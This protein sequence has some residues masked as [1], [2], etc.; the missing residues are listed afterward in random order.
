MKT[1][2]N[3]FVIILVLSILSPLAI[4]SKL[5]SGLELKMRNMVDNEKTRVL[6][7]MKEKAELDDVRGNPQLV[8]QKL[9]TVA[10]KSQRQSLLTISSLQN[11]SKVPQYRSFWIVNCISVTG[12]KGAIKQLVK[13]RNVDKIIE[14]PVIPLPSPA[15]SLET[16]TTPSNVQW[17]I[18]QIGIDRVW[19]DFGYRGEGIVIGCIDTGVD[20]SHPELVNKMAYIGNGEV[21]WF[22]AVR[23]TT[24]P[25]DISDIPHGTHVMGTMVGGNLSGSY[26][27]VAPNAKYYMAK[28]F[29]STGA[30]GTDILEAAQWMMDPDDNPETDDFPDVI[31]NSWGGT[32][33][34]NTWFE[35]MYKSWEA[36]GIFSAFAGGNAGPD[37]NTISDPAG[38]PEVFAVG[39]TTSTDD[40]ASFSS[41]G[42]VYWQ[43]RDGLNPPARTVIKPDI[44]APGQGIKSSVPG[45]YSSWNGTSMAT[46][47]IT[48]IA[49]LIR[50]ANPQISLQQ[51][52]K[53]LIDNSIDLG[54]SGKDNNFGYGRVDAY[55]A[56]S[57][58]V[59]GGTLNG[60]VS[61]DSQRISNAVVEVG[62]ITTKTDANGEF[63]LILQAG[64]Y[65]VKVSKV[66]YVTKE[67]SGIV[68]E[69]G[70]TKSLNITILPA[71]S[72]IIDGTVTD[73]NNSQPVSATVNVISTDISDNTDASTGQ[74]SF[75]LPEGQY[76]IEVK[77]K[78]YR[79]QTVSVDVIADDTVTQDFLL[80]PYDLAEPNDNFDSAFGINIG[81]LFEADINPA[82]DQDFYS[83]QGSSG[84]RVSIDVDAGSLSPTSELDSILTLYDKNQTLI[85]END[86]YNDFDPRINGFSLPS[87]GIYYVRVKSFWDDVGGENYFYVLKIEPSAPNNLIATS[88][89]DSK[90]VLEWDTVI[91]D[92]LS[93]MNSNQ[94]TFTVYNIYKSETPNVEVIES[95]K[96]NLEPI[97]VT[98]YVDEN[99]INGTTYYYVVTAIFD[100]GET[101]PSNEV[102]ARPGLTDNYE[103]N[104]DFA[105]A[106]EINYFDVVSN[107]TINP[108]DDHD[109]F[110]FSGI[111]GQRIR[112]YIE[113]RSLEPPSQ[114]DSILYLY[115]ANQQILTQNN[116]YNEQ[117]SLIEFK[118][119]EDG[120]YFLKVKS[121]QAVGGEEYFY[122]LNIV[123]VGPAELQAQSG[124]ER[125]VILTWENNFETNVSIAQDTF[126]GY[127][128]YRNTMPNVP[129]DSAYLINSNPI[130]DSNYEDTDVL[131]GTAYYYVITTVYESGES[132]P[133]NE[134]NAMPGPADEY[135]PNN[136]FEHATTIDYNQSITDVTIDPA[137]DIDFFKFSG[138]SEILVTIDV[139]AESLDPSSQLDSVLT[140]YDAN[141][142]EISNNDDFDGRDS[143]IEFFKLTQNDIYYIKV[144]DYYSSNG[145]QD[146]N[147]VLTVKK[148]GPSNLEAQSKE[149][150]IELS[151]SSIPM[152]NY[153]PT[154]YSNDIS[155]SS[156]TYNIYRTE[157]PGV[158]A[159]EENRINELPVDNTSYEDTDVTSGIKYYYVVTAIING[160]ETAPS[161][162]VN[163]KAGLADAYEPNDEFETAYQISFGQPIENATI[164][165]SGDLDY[166][167][168]TGISGQLVT[169]DVN[170]E[171][172]ESP[173]ELDSVLTLFDSNHNE[174]VN[175]DD[176]DG[177]DPRIE[178]F[179]LPRDG[180][181]YIRI[182]PFFLSDG[183]EEFFYNLII[184][185][186]ISFNLRAQS[187]DSHVLL[188][189]D[190]VTQVNYNPTKTQS[191]EQIGPQTL[192]GYNV[193]RSESSG[194]EISEENRLN[195]IPIKE[196]SYDD[197]SVENGNSYFY[198]VTAVF[199]T[200]ESAPSKEVNATP[201]IPD[202]YEPNDDM[203]TATGIS[204]SASLENAIIN[205]PEV[206][207]DWY[208]F[209]G[210]AGQ[211]VIIETLVDLSLNV[212]I[213]LV[214]IDS[215]GN[216]LAHPEPDSI[217][218]VIEDFQLSESGIYYIQVSGEFVDGTTM[219]ENKI[220]Y[221]I[222]IDL[223]PP[224]NLTAENGLENRIPLSWDAPCNSQNSLTYNVYRRES[225][226]LPYSKIN[227]E[228]PI[229]DT[230]FDDSRVEEGQTYYY[231]VTTIYDNIE[232]CFSNEALGRSG[233]IDPNEP[234]DEMNIATSIEVGER[235]SSSAI[236]SINDKDYYVF[237]ASKEQGIVIDI[238]SRING[239]K[240]DSI[241]TL[242]DRDGET[243]LMV[244]DDFDGYDSRIEISIPNDGAYYAE[245]T[246]FDG[247]FGPEYYYEISVKRPDPP[248]ELQAIG[249]RSSILLQW[250]SPIGVQFS[251]AKDTQSTHQPQKIVGYNIYRGN[252]S[253]K[254]NKINSALV[255]ETF[256]QDT[257]VAK[258]T[259][260][261]YAVSAVYENG[262]SGYSNESS[263]STV[264]LGDVNGEEGITIIDAG[265]VLKHVVGN[266]NITGD[267]YERADVSGDGNVT[268]YDATLIIQYVYGIIETF[269]ADN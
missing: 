106:Y 226:N 109:Y 230:Y 162:E 213:N 16:E 18:S 76:D 101:E 75:R 164:D 209:K 176:F 17:N 74:Y 135:E 153:N 84:Q 163:A 137:G 156:I 199:D 126:I 102:S 70:R 202:P 268:S 180:I 42:P 52:R 21:G 68:I 145:G 10:Q 158:E 132:L 83:F 256:W 38:Y 223:S 46:P 31:N 261:F 198:V 152:V 45:G 186:K 142:N 107:A 182:E 34:N 117:D 81:E 263:A 144:E 57:A 267:A 130:N 141:F 100:S 56:I 133:S 220:P 11:E 219:S 131:N 174:I 233:V 1:F 77:A 80:E 15:V 165:P 159:I 111:G 72:G 122:N 191:E 192:S 40:I 6:V 27:G 225:N 79:S 47:H 170:A 218:P 221:S 160:E 29:T 229:T 234:N 78:G 254:R 110:S 262:E 260:Y 37:S 54:V 97:T 62:D 91:T 63:S 115:D 259:K 140:L 61:G 19:S 181:Y 136:D 206:D 187:G 39:A 95:N 114:L 87:T 55:N 265:L 23:G 64:T 108:M 58:V 207:L 5:D 116:D 190:A 214:L 166:F 50:Q 12:T 175:N 253:G 121:L 7:F 73:V 249:Q 150:S 86:D 22:D 240:L 232:S 235:I 149:N 250:E 168:F 71:S 33:P 93:I 60:V 241:L 35:A 25:G 252:I 205:P 211:I 138:I 113:A 236:Q 189:W 169:I 224:K 2:R 239:S 65:T 28:A 53:V 183:G 266:I 167:Y 143:R 125:K 36:M 128:I 200:G 120:Q 43:D 26:I 8:L 59:N 194:V 244:N 154:K 146:Y 105:N 242:Y 123:T 89:L 32:N 13:S 171:S 248:T 255:T 151:W 215:N 228:L 193:Y 155:L 82:G 98:T 99:V 204:Y 69:K 179:N 243:P 203:Q 148:C 118:L 96:I 94:S 173:S 184:T 88:G 4:A 24:T 212:S 238:D 112:A 196:F 51:T 185:T 269:P 264:L 258:D 20:A 129:I 222:H 247:G 124:L 85:K 134:V 92:S 147:Y 66:G 67:I 41:R 188:T 177:V 201:G 231:V 195:N 161:N 246:G 208:K 44:C 103:P 178:H 14:D 245:V 217:K 49:A 197:I 90:V 257:E 119:P 48:A 216:E 3:Y 104:N 237:S 210:T 139:D 127:N 172:L 9:K 251:P 157:S 227:G 30:T